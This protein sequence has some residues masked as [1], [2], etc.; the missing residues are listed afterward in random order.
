MPIM[1]LESTAAAAP[2]A[3]GGEWGQV[4]ADAWPTPS[5]HPHRFCPET[6]NDVMAHRGRHLL[7][8]V[9]IS[10]ALRLGLLGHAYA[11]SAAV[12]FTINVQPHTATSPLTISVQPPS[13][14]PSVPSE[15]AA[16]DFT[17]LAANYDFSQ[18]LYAT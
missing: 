12:P 13:S 4:R 11:G 15:A 14:G 3:K 18:P 16:A 7:D 2:E 6:G 9:I 1:N 17:T 5:V 8:L 10:V